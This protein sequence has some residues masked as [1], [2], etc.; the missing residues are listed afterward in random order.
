MTVA[1]VVLSL[2]GLGSVG[3]IVLLAVK[4]SAAK[5]AAVAA[6]RDVLTANRGQLAAEKLRDEAVA[7]LAQRTA[8]RDAALA[9]LTATQL[10]DVVSAKEN[11]DHVHDSIAVAAP[12]DAAALL[13]K[14][15]SSGFD[16][17]AAGAA[18][19]A[20]AGGAGDASAPAVQPAAAAGSVTGG[21]SR[22]G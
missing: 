19:V 7:A 21:A 12:A 16:L 15:L 18:S 5:D 6:D 3:G 1:I 14:Q 17:P 2:F 4:L 22:S 10:A 11:A 13:D 20:A 8:E 9:Q